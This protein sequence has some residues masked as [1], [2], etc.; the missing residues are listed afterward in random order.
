MDRRSA[1][2]HVVEPLVDLLSALLLVQEAATTPDGL[3]TMFL[4]RREL[5]L[6]RV[7]R[8]LT[9][10]RA[11]TTRGAREQAHSMLKCI[12]LIP[13]P[14]S[15]FLLIQALRRLQPHCANRIPLLTP[16]RLSHLSPRRAPRPPV[17]PQSDNERRGPHSPPHLNPRIASSA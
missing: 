12:H 16:S 9:Q 13:T 4:K 10:P 2:S 1:A 8:C 3:E 15:P 6:D 17:P 11:G 14:P 7:V 5:C